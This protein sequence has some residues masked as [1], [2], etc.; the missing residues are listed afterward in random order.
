M[1]ACNYCG[2][3]ILFG[4]IKEGDRRF[5]GKD[6]HRKGHSLVLAESKIPQEF[7]T[8]KTIQIHQGQCPKCNGHGPV[9]V[10][11][12]HRVYSLLF[13]TSW[14]SI[15]EICCRSCGVKRQVGGAVFS[16]LLGWWG[17]PWG[18]IM[19]PVQIVRNIKAIVTY[20]ENSRPSDKL[21]HAV[22]GWLAQ[23]L[24]E[25]QPGAVMESR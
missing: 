21:A 24:I 1:A 3:T 12:S 10:H 7:I 15:P 5:C 22:K 2:T 13:M 23:Q 11:T 19:T 8:R 20:S 18:L 25:K 9:D 16:A 17:F 4:G 6:C 14:K